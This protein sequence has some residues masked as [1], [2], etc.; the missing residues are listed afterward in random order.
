MSLRRRLIELVFAGH[1]DPFQRIEI[2]VGS[3]TSPN[4]VVT[5][6]Q[7][8]FLIVDYNGNAADQDVYINSNGSTTWIHI[9]D[10]DA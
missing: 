5:A 2:Q 6:P 10:G 3:G 8:T 7:G 9:H 1:S 4:G